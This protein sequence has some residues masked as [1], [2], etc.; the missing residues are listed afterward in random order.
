MTDDN[1]WAYSRQHG[2]ACRIV[3]TELIWGKKTHRVWLPNV[4]AV[5]RVPDD[6]LLPSEQQE[7]LSPDAI[8]YAATAARIADAISQDVLL[9]PLE[10]AVIPLPHQIRTLS[11]AISGDRIRYLLADEVGLGKTIEAGL[12]M[13]EL[14]LRGLVKRTL[15]VAPKGLVSQWVSEMRTH[16]EER[17]HL[18][19]SEDLSS[20]G[21]LLAC[22]TDG[23]NVPWS[24][25]RQGVASESEENSNPWKLFSQ[26]VVSMDSVK[27]LERRR[28][29]S[30][31]KL[32]TYNRLRFEG[33]ISAD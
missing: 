5:V 11:R 26:V 20:L 28:G 25:M 29:W 15:V 7:P 4:D 21:R 30:Q 6:D 18:V 8:V 27:P 12:I 3:E 22:D 14:K 17:F 24:L 23:E 33:L 13:R 2:Q 10:S 16:F 9:A 19:L 1:R 31:E 32:L